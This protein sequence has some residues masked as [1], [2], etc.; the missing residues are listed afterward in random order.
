MDYSGNLFVNPVAFWGLGPCNPDGAPLEIKD[1][2]HAAT[3]M[4]LDLGPLDDVKVAM[5]SMPRWMHRN[6]KQGNKNTRHGGALHFGLATI[7]QLN[8]RDG[9]SIRTH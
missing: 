4:H 8:K 7:Q 2:Q 9:N 1:A 6:E 5:E 3:Q